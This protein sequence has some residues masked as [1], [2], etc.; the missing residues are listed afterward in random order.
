[1]EINK[2]HVSMKGNEYSNNAVMN[3]IEQNRN[4]QIISNHIC[5]LAHVCW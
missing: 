5:S 1:M 2:N 4:F 3:N